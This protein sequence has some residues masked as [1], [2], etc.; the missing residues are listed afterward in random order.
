MGKRPIKDSVLDRPLPP[1]VF[2]EGLRKISPAVAHDT[3]DSCLVEK[4]QALFEKYG[5]VR[6]KKLPKVVREFIQKMAVE[7]GI[8]GFMHREEVKTPGQP[9][10]WLGNDGVLLY[11]RVEQHKA[12]F[13]K[14]TKLTDIMKDI[15]AEYGYKESAENLYT[16][17]Y[18][19]LD[20]PLSYI[21][22]TLARKNNKP[23][24]DAQRQKILEIESLL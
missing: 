20:N 7:Y 23:L 13:P 24:T 9:T 6:P 8:V 17:Y 18:G 3:L 4:E 19:M 5:L 11:N 16:R 14:K 12:K 21:S 2:I 15:K 10:K 1:K 22:I